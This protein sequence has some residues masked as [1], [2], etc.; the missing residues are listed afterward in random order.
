[1]SDEHT[2]DVGKHVRAYVLVFTAL[3][4]LTVIT[5]AASYLHLATPLAIGLALAIASVKGALV[6]CYFMHLISERRLIYWVLILTVA[7]FAVLLFVPLL[8]SLD[9][10]GP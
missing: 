7:F 1:M 6:A 4:V 9:E 2:I 8:T 3:L 5:V 10:V